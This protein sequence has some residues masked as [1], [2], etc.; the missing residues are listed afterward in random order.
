MAKSWDF[1]SRKTHKGRF[2]MQNPKAKKI[3][4]IVLNTLVWIFLVFAILVTI[5]TFASQNAKD[6]VPSVFGKSI[7]SIQSDSMKSSAKE[8]FKK[9]DLI[10]IEK[11]SAD[12]AY[13]LKKGT[14]ITYRAPIDIDGDGKTGDINTHRID[15]VRVSEGD[16]VFFTTKGDNPVTNPTVDNYELRYTDVIGV[17]HGQKLVGVGGVLDFFRSSVGF[18]LVIVLPMALFFFYEVYNLVKIIMAHKLSK[19]KAEALSPE[20]EE[21]IKRLAIQEY[22]ASQQAASQ[23]PQPEK[24]EQAEQPQTEQNSTNTEEKE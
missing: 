2:L 22:L 14:I 8:S 23:A 17:Y 3:V 4:S 20:Q 12:K 11:I 1:F 10:I 15:S 9:G 16:I 6:G 13:E 24:P 21:E 19:A 18:F 7:V 5:V